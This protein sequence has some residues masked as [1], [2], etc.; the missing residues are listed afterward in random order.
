MNRIARIASL[1]LVAVLVLG[2]A[3]PAFATSSQNEEE[4]TTE[5]TLTS[6]PTWETPPAVVV[7]ASSAEEEELP[8]TA[9][10]IYPTIAAAAVLLVVGLAIGYNRSIRKKYQV[11]S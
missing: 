2:L 11:I 6:E 3:A 5:T 1:L 4:E 10:F 7:P 8:W 9:R